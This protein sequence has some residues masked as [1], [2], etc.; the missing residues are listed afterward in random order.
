M[1]VHGGAVAGTGEKGGPF[2]VHA[3][4]L[5]KHINY[6]VSERNAQV[7]GQVGGPKQKTDWGGGGGGGGAIKTRENTKQNKTKHTTNTQTKTT[8]MKARA[9]TKQRERNPDACLIDLTNKL[10]TSSWGFTTPSV[11]PGHLRTDRTFT[12]TPHQVDRQVTK[13]QVKR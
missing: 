10:L 3:G 5:E 11:T 1:F 9:T 13:T 4:N 12:V 8:T 2:L 7:G 6:I